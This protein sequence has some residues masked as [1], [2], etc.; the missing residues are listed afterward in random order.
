MPTLLQQVGSGDR[1]HWSETENSSP[2]HVKWTLTFLGRTSTF[3]YLNVFV[4]LNQV[5]FQIQH[6]IRTIQQHFFEVCEGFL[7]NQQLSSST[8]TNIYPDLLIQYPPDKNPNSL[9]LL[10]IRIYHSILLQSPIE[11]SSYHYHSH[12]LF[13]SLSSAALTSTP[14]LQHSA[15]TQLPKRTNRKNQ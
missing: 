12:P 9:T 15:C 2:A 3:S 11:I 10:T 5:F 4:L 8:R 7:T 13:I 6:S 14:Q 1:S